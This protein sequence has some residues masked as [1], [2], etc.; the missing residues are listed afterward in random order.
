MDGD[1]RKQAEWKDSKETKKLRLGRER[2]REKK[3]V[4]QTKVSICCSLTIGCVHFE[5]VLSLAETYKASKREMQRNKQKMS[6]QQMRKKETWGEW[7]RV[8][9]HFIGTII[10]VYGSSKIVNNTRI[11]VN[12]TKYLFFVTIIQC[13]HEYLVS[14]WR[15]WSHYKM[16]SLYIIAVLIVCVWI[17]SNTTFFFFVVFHLSFFHD[18]FFCCSCWCFLFS[19]CYYTHS[20]CR[21]S[22]ENANEHCMHVQ[23][24][25]GCY[26]VHR[27]FMYQ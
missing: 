4:N 22:N 24:K 23:I 19:C 8:D 16:L 2:E 25:L 20:I 17:S 27:L 10:R 6:K 21:C 9:A 26:C 3:I 14:L 12:I 5:C 13:L 1:E 11:A 15:V 7:A 18:S